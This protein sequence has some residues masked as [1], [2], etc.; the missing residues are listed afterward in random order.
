MDFQIRKATNLD[1]EAIQHV[2]ITSWHH[3]YQEL[4]PN[5]VQD[6]F[7]EKYYNVETLHNRISATPF[8]VLEQANKV[9]GFAN[10]IELEKGKSELAAFYLLPEVTQRGLGT[11]LLEEGMTLFHVPLPTSDVC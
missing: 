3:T 5:D 7:L 10:F 4:I 11:E 8:A 9:I 6:G 2:A 1:A